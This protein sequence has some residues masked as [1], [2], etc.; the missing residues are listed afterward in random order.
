MTVHCACGDEKCTQQMWFSGFG[1]ELWIKLGDNTEHLL[2]MD[3]ETLIQI[4][5]EA[6]QAIQDM[7]IRA[8]SGN[9]S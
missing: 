8:V 6:R 3:A 2:Y 7:V 9:D 5:I 1:H 4:I